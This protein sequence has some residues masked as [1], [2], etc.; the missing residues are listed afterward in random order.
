M[1]SHASLAHGQVIEYIQGKQAKSKCHQAHANVLQIVCILLRTRP[2]LIPTLPFPFRPRPL[3]PPSVQQKHRK[4][5]CELQ[6]T[7][8]PC[9][10]QLMTPF[11]TMRSTRISAHCTSVTCT[12]S[13]FTSTRSLVTQPM[14]RGQWFFTANPILGAARM[15]HAW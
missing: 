14:P 8:S 5:L 15:Q 1:P 9:T 10:L 6:N 13:P 7:N 3:L 12:A 11:Y 4:A 2:H